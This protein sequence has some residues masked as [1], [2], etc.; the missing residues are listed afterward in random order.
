M[1][2]LTKLPN[3]ENALANFHVRPDR[4]IR[5]REVKE[6]KEADFGE[7]MKTIATGKGDL[8]GIYD[9]KPAP[10]APLVRPKRILKPTELAKRFF[11]PAFVQKPYMKEP[12]EK[13]R[14]F[15]VLAQAGR[16]QA[17]VH[18]ARMGY[19]LVEPEKHSG[20]FNGT[21][22]FI[23][24]DASQQRMKVEAKSSKNLRPWDIIQCM[25]YGQPGD[26]IAISTLSEFLEPEDWLVEM[27][28]SVARD[29]A[30]FC[31]ELPEVAAGTH[32]PY[33]GLCERCAKSE[34][35]YKK[36]N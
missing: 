10:L 3:P 18:M 13:R 6:L 12:L 5:G 21:V 35:V 30:R 19:H 16:I 14:Q 17:I 34:C 23:F 27:V 8:R 15:E 22:D 7:V 26:K 31:E 4:I 1:G 33:R 36:R 28:N 24:E 32:M 11:C 25:L 9:Q 2:R 20:D 29:F